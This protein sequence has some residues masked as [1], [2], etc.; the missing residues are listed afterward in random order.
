MSKPEHIFFNSSYETIIDGPKSVGPE[1]VH[2][3]EVSAL[4]VPLIYMYYTQCKKFDFVTGMAYVITCSIYKYKTLYFRNMH[5]IMASH[6]SCNFIYSTS[7]LL[8]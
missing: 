2:L 7:A 6:A 4:H 3:Y 8:S 5:I 1:V